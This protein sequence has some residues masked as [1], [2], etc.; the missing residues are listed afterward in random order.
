VGRR[1]TR[2]QIKKDQFVSLVDRGAHWVGQNWRQAA[3]GLG[4]AVGI[5][6]LY[7]A[8]TAGVDAR[9]AAAANA[10]TKALETYNAPVGAAAP[11]NAKIKFATD[12]ERLD[13]ADTAFRAV[14]SKYWLT[15]PARHAKLY[16]ARIAADRGDTDAAVRLLSEITSRRSSNAIVRLAMLD[17]VRLR[18]AKGEGQQLVGDLEAM[19]AGKDPRLPRD[20][21]T[22][23]LARMWERE[24]KPA[25]AAKL[26]RQLIENFPE[27]P[28][29][30][31]AQQRLTA[32]S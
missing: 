29:R 2:K 11:A 31:D 7:W 19:V 27:S 4:G 32:V 16:L 25:E 30:P 28:Y 10:L 21:A 6:V 15:S 12:T 5:A 1:L 8:V 9:A 22:F 23:E 20:V 3:I 18:V 14:S 24:G 26:Y 13:A 17:L